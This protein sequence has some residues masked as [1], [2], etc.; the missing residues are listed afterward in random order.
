MLEN[1]GGGIGRLPDEATR[2]RMAELV[3]A[4]PQVAG[5]APQNQ[6]PAVAVPAATLDLY[7]GEYKTAAGSV[8]TFR[9]DGE[10]L[11]V[12][13][14]NSPEAA[15]IARSQTRFSDPRGPVIEFQLDDAGKVTGIIVEQGNGQKVP[16]SRIQ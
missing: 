16:A 6:G 13:P 7:A 14:G 2:K 8:L 15:L 11:L 5:P 12:K 10:T 3:D 9:R 4:L 1:I